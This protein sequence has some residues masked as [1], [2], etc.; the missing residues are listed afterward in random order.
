L[1]AVFGENAHHMDCFIYGKWNDDTQSFDFDEGKIN[2]LR[3]RTVDTLEHCKECSAKD[4]CGGYCIGE[5]V[6]ETGTL[7]GQKSQV[8]KAIRRLFDEL[9]S[10]KMQYKYLHP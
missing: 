4:Y 8:C 5:I 2:K 1:H 10:F 7:D 6:N 9:G 3:R